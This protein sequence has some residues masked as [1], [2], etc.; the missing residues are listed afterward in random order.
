M[1]LVLL[2]SFLWHNSHSISISSFRY[3]NGAL[4]DQTFLF[5]RFL[6]SI[7]KRDKYRHSSRADNPV[8]HGKNYR[9]FI[10]IAHQHRQSGI[11]TRGSRRGNTGTDIK[12]S[13]NIRDH[14]E[15]ADLPH[16]IAQNAILPASA[17]ARLVMDTPARL[18]QPKPPAMETA[19]LTG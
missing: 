11:L 9:L 17:P 3:S 10:R 15:G 18:Y 14:K 5:H 4:Q 8:K 2:F 13:G 7:T 1:H 16:Q 19:C 6:H 12:M